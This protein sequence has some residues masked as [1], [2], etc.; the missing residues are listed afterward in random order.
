MAKAEKV[1]VT[2]PVPFNVVLT[3][4]REEAEAVIDVLGMVGGPPKVTRRKY[5]DAVYY[6]LAPL[7]GTSIDRGTMHDKDGSISFNK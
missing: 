5:T 3:L 7:V 1:P 4:S 6:A 2:Q